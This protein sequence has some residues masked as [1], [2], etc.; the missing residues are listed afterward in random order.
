MKLA[1]ATL[2]TAG[3]L[4]VAA[5]TP[6]YSGKS[7]AAQPGLYTAAQAA[8]G[9]KDY[10]QNCSRCHGVNLEGVSAPPL[11]GSDF[12]GVPGGSGKL[13]IHD[14]F[15]YMTSLMPAGNAGSLSHDTY[16][17]IMAYIL[18]ENG[19]PAGSTALTYAAA[20]KSTLPIKK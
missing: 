20:M 3:I 17:A 15:K 14:I 18:K 2:V 19:S 12:S 5:V 13:T 7:A 16:A 6:L 4:A 10:A 1:H 11:K 9:A 8:T